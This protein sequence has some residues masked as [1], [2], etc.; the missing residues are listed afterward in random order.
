MKWLV[1]C[2]TCALLGFI[3]A[4]TGRQQ[5]HLN[6]VRIGNALFVLSGFFFVVFF[7][8]VGR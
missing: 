8:T 7:L 4:T 1:W 6:M 2:L 3:A 5:T